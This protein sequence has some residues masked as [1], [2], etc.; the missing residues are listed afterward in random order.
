MCT[1]KFMH[2]ILKKNIYTYTTLL[3]PFTQITEEIRAV[4]KTKQTQ[5]FHF[6]KELSLHEIQLKI[7]RN[8]RFSQVQLFFII[9]FLLSW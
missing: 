1:H 7:Y 2:I 5:M 6:T 8:L 4:A 9:T 3:F